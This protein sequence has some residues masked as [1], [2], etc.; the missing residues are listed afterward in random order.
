M[1]PR[2]K[3]I[4][5]TSSSSLRSLVVKSGDTLSSSLGVAVSDTE[6]RRPL[7]SSLRLFAYKSVAPLL[8]PG[9][10]HILDHTRALLL[11]PEGRVKKDGGTLSSSLGTAVLY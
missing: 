9:R 3:R 11:L 10:G 5:K 7:S 6:L 8:L 2:L 4:R 1:P